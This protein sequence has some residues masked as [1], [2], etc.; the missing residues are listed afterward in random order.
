MRR[1]QAAALGLVQGVAE[2]VPVS[3]SAQLV[4]LPRL[5]GWPDPPHRTAFAAL[6]HAGSTLGLAVALRAELRELV[7]TSRGRRRVGVFAATCLPAAVAGLA[8]HDDVEQRLG[9]PRQVAVL[10]GAAGA[11]M[12]AADR[13]TERVDEVR[14]RDAAAAAAAQLL[15]LAPGVSRHGATLTA[16]RLCG[17]ERAA[18]T[19][20]SLLMSMPVTGGAALVPLAKA[21]RATLRALARLAAVGLPAATGAAAAAA[22][23]WRRDP[24]RPLT[25]A[26]VYRL[27]VA[28]LTLARLRTRSRPG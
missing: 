5:L 11:F 16:L 18:A 10:L 21:D 23:V 27:V 9:S 13:R 6:L 19:R 15:A 8:L 14:P 12:W 25:A 17:V 24:G 2:V 26:A 20:F 3:S 4:L 1:R 7:T 28:A 22:A